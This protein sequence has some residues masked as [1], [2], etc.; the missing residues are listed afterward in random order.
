LWVTDVIYVSTWQGFVYVAFVIDVFARRIVGWRVSFS[1]RTEFVL[2]AL[3]QALHA[4]RGSGACY[5]DLSCCCPAD[6]RASVA[7]RIRA[8]FGACSQAFPSYRRMDE[9]TDVRFAAIAASDQVW[10]AAS[11]PISTAQAHGPERLGSSR[12]SRHSVKGSTQHEYAHR[13]LCTQILRASL[14]LLLRWRRWFHVPVRRSRTS[15]LEFT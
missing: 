8:S 6:C 3:E 10:A 14:S 4:R 13:R 7:A 11:D 12:F 2:D 15:G 1:M 9:S 5:V